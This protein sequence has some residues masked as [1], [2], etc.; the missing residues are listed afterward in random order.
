MKVVSTSGDKD[1]CPEDDATNKEDAI[2]VH[3]KET[4]RA[5]ITQSGFAARISGSENKSNEN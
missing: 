5:I 1:E 3:V 4:T 2:K